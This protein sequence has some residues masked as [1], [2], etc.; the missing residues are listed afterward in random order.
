MCIR[1]SDDTENTSDPDPDILEDEVQSL[2]RSSTQW[3]RDNNMVCAGE[4]TIQID[5]CGV[6]VIETQSEKLLGMYVSND[7]SWRT[8]LHGNTVFIRLI[9]ARIIR[10]R[11][12]KSGCAS[13]FGCVYY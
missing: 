12:Q 6:S 1:D 9:A 3:V 11:L 2:A 7:L 4:K 5:V 8:Q 10:I 13:L